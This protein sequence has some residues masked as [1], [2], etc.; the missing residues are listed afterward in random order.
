MCLYEAAMIRQTRAIK[1]MAAGWGGGG[2][3]EPEPSYSAR[4]KK[5]SGE[6][7]KKSYLPPWAV[8]PSQG[9]E[10]TPVYGKDQIASLPI[11]LGYS[12]I[13]SEE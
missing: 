6:P 10:V 4:L 11:K 13:D 12:I 1:A 7:E 3:S 2:D 9:G 5:Q 8:D